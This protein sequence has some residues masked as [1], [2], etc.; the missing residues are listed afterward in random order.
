LVREPANSLMVAGVATVVVWGLYLT[1]LL[2]D[3]RNAIH[4]GDVVRVVV[5]AGLIGASITSGCLMV[6]GAIETR[7]LRS[8]AWA[9]TA[10][11]VALLPW[12]GCC[13][14]ALLPVGIQSLR[15]LARKEV[16]DAFDR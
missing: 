11:V 5:S 10:S 13:W 14:I 6:F 15:L 7:N 8:L 16:R 4:I 12:L 3:I 2:N 1:E 9:R